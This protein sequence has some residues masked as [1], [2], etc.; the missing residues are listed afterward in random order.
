MIYSSLDEAPK[1]HFQS[2]PSTEMQAG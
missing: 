1:M 2:C